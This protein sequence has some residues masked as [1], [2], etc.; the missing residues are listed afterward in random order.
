MKWEVKSVRTLNPMLV[1]VANK[2]GVC[3]TGGGVTTM[4]AHL[5]VCDQKQHSAIRAQ[6]L[7]TWRTESFSATLTPA[8]HV[9]TASETYA[10]LPAT[11]LRVGTGA[12]IFQRADND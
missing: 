9:Y 2:K 7:G 6:I 12:T 4:A 11:L 5:F 3:K 10:E 8:T 1:T